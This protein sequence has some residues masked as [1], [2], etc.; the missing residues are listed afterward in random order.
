MKYANKYSI[1]TSIVEEVFTLIKDCETISDIPFSKIEK[2]NTSFFRDNSVLNVLENIDGIVSFNFEIDPTLALKNKIILNAAIFHLVNSAIYNP[3]R[4]SQSN[5][6]YTT[7]KASADNP[8][9]LKQAGIKFYSPDQKLG[10]HNDVFIENEKYFIPKYVSLTNLFIGYNNPGNFYYIN[11]NI[12][13]KFDDLFTQGEG[14]RFKFKVTPVVRESDLS[15]PVITSPSQD[16]TLVPVFWKNSSGTKFVF[17]NGEL[18]D[19]EDTTIITELKQSLLDNPIKIL[20]PQADNQVIVFRN[21]IGFHSRD[22]F[23]EQYIMEGTTR[24]FLRAVSK[25]S[26]DLPLI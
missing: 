19:N 17:S 26:I 14:K 25:D 21:D 6:P 5:L 23:R 12:W 9:K 1:P 22:I 16:W 15:Q 24:L 13:E 20:V 11:Q 3:V 8:D 18:K 10:Y 7:Y 2:I 4:E